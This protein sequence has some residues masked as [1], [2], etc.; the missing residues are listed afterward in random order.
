MG[1]GTQVIIVVFDDDKITVT[2]Q[3][4]TG[5]HNASICG[6]DDSLSFTPCDIDPLFPPSEEEKFS[7][8]LPSVGQRHAEIGELEVI[9][10]AVGSVELTTGAV[11]GA[12]TA[13]AV[14]LLFGN[15]LLAV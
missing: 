1:V 5:I 7:I 3:S 15:I 2:A 12:V 4:V 11:T 8:T 13:V 9:L 14:P 10:L 6:R